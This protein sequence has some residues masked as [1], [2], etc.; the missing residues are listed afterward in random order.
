M[1]PLPAGDAH[2]TLIDQAEVIGRILRHLGLWEAGVRVDAA[3]DPPEPEE[4]ILEPWLED[5]F[6][7]DDPEPVF[8][9]N[10]EP[11]QRR[12]APRKPAFSLISTPSGWRRPVLRGG[13]RATHCGKPDS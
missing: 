10:S 8:A 4:R 11:R 6:P 2:P 12:G 3:R 9:Q 5:P 13:V 1:P 7:D